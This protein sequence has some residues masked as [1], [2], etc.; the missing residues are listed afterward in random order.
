METGAAEVE[1]NSVG[2]SGSTVS[3]P[4][5][6]FQHRGMKRKHH[7]SHSEGNKHGR[8]GG[9][10][11]TYHPPHKKA[12]QDVSSTRAAN[13]IMRFRLGGSVSDPL[14]LQGGDDV[15]DKCSTCAPSPV[16][17]VNEAVNSPSHL[18]P[19][20]RKDPLNLE[21]KVKN[22]PVPGEMPIALTLV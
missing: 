15:E 21:E 20:L 6:K 2:A 17:N 1:L 22:F 12:K 7:F 13:S 14:N 5:Q 11:H 19:A 3:H 8:G 18:P 16:T 10:H 9:R 4:T